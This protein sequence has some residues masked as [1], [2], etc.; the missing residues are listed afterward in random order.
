MRAFHFYMAVFFCIAFCA[1]D[2][3]AADLIQSG[4]SFPLQGDCATNKLKDI[5]ND[6]TLSTWACFG[7]SDTQLDFRYTNG[8]GESCL[9]IDN[10]SSPQHA[11]FVPLR[12][13]AEWIAFKRA[14]QQNGTLNNQVFLSY[15]CKA[16]DIP[17]G[18]CGGGVS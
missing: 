12:T 11:F 8:A 16:E 15:G 14:T 5:S 10:D 9:Y 3:R 13:D 4:F 18:Q 1:G 2:A 6:P 17:P 7:L